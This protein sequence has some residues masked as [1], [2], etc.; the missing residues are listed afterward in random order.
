MTIM[1][2]LTQGGGATPVI[3]ILAIPSLQT[4]SN[5]IPQHF[6]DYYNELSPL[7][8]HHPLI[9]AIINTNFTVR[10]LFCLS[11]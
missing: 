6:V 3:N 9:H 4:H 8:C 7:P 11:A 10:P 1:H 2:A 5:I